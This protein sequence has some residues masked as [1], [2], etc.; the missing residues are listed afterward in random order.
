MSGPLAH[1]MWCC[2]FDSK[3]IDEY[4]FGG[5]TPSSSALFLWLF[6]AKAKADSLLFANVVRD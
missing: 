1:W 6:V 2:V 4:C 5:S 3:C